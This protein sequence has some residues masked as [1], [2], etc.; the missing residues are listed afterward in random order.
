MNKYLIYLLLVMFSMANANPNFSNCDYYSIY[1][2]NLGEVSWGPDPPY[3]GAM[4]NVTYSFKGLQRNTTHLVYVVASIVRDDKQ[5]DPIASS[6]VKVDRNVKDVSVS[7]NVQ[8]P[9]P[10]D[11]KNRYS[12]VVFLLDYK[13]GEYS[14]IRFYDRYPR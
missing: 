3:A 13:Y 9:S 4:L 1:T 2:D 12:L 8:W 10:A 5:T 7:L 6:K 11:K 14:C